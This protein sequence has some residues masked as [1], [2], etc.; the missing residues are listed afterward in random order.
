MLPHALSSPLSPVLRTLF[1]ST[2]PRTPLSVDPHLHYGVQIDKRAL[3]RDV[4]TAS[5]PLPILFVLFFLAEWGE[6]GGETPL[7]R[8]GASAHG[9]V[10]ERQTGTGLGYTCK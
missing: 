9:C 3:T 7:R 10:E 2:T 8:Q 1:S 4:Q 5:P 6:R